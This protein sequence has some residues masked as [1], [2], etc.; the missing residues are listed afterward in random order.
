MQRGPSSFPAIADLHLVAYIRPMFVRRLPIFG[1]ICAIFLS[2]QGAA[3][4]AGQGEAVGKMVICTGFGTHVVFVDEN[5]ERTTPPQ[6]CADAF[7]C[8]VALPTP[9]QDVAAPEP[10]TLDAYAHFLAHRRDA[11][12]IPNYAARAPPKL[13]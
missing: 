10:I 13:V 1:L 4:A 6:L 9:A 2:A 3:F 8:F 11:K 5:G 7:K 12:L